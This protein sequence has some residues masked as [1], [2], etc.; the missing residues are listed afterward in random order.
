[1]DR[2]LEAGVT[3]AFVDADPTWARLED[4]LGWYDRK[5]MSC[6]AAYK[7]TKLAQLVVAAAVPVLA[8]ADVAAVATAVAAAVVVVLEGVQQLYQ[9]QANWIMYRST[10]EALKHERFLYQAMAGPYRGNDRR[11]VL[12]EKI[13]GLVSQEHAKWTETSR[14]TDGATDQT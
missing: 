11:L 2:N 7:R 12:A 10:A 5:S 1:M 3:S 13:E 9:W 8:L 6:Q 14:R 4:Q